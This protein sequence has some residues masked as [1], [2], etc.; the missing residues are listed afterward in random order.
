MWV[1]YSQ[2]YEQVFSSAKFWRATL[3]KDTLNTSI[4]DQRKLEQEA[5][6]Q[7]PDQKIKEN[8]EIITSIEDCIDSIEEYFKLGFTKVYVCSTSPFKMEFIREFGKK[9]ILPYIQEQIKKS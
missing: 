5:K 6:Q 1:S 3:L 8:I 4:S 9:G 7:V 2:N